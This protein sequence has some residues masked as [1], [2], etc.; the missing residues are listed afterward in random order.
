MLKRVPS[1]LVFFVAITLQAQ[2]PIRV[3]V[4]ATDAARK[5]FHAHLTIPAAPGPMKLAYAKWIPGEHSPT[6]PIVDLVNLRIAANGT[7]V[8]WRRDPG[9]MFVFLLDAPAGTTSLDVDLTYLSPIAGGNF[10]A[11]PNSTANLA[12]L[13]WNTLLLF[14][15]GKDAN[16]IFIEG[17][18]K[19]PDG[20]K[21]ASALPQSN[22]SFERASLA[23]YVDSP[24]IIGRYLKT[25]AIP[26]ASG[27]PAHRI[28]IVSESERDLIAPDDLAKQYARLA[29]EAGA[30]FGSYHFA[31][32][33]WLVSLSD[34]VAHFGLE[35]HQ[36]SDN[37]L[38]EATLADENGLRGL[39]GLLSHEYVH[40][41]NG[42]YRRPAA[43]LS[44]DYQQP[45]DGTL[46][47]V[48]EGLTEYMGFLLAARSGLWTPEHYRENLASLAAYYDVQPGRAWR[49]LADTATAA[50]IL[51]GAAEA[52]S[53]LRRSVDFYDESVLV[54]LEVDSILR[55]RTN[56]KA[57][58]DDFTRR[59]HGGRSGVAEVK[60]YT[61]DDVVTTLNAIAPYDWRSHFQSRVY[62]RTP[63]APLAG[64][65]ANGWK[66]AFD[67]KPNEAVASYETRRKVIDLTWSIG[68]VLREDGTVRDALMG[69]PAAGAGIG[70][71][72]KIIA[73]NGRRFTREVLES[74]L[75]DRSALELIVENNNFFRTH[76]V[77]YTGGVRYPHLVRDETVKDGLSELIA[78]KA[79]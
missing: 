28:N 59:F 58:L 47:W 24:V 72:M 64:L 66:L 40:S 25:F 60:P 30:A 37:R 49:P 70:P 3:S 17:S 26:V 20:W 69:Q 19:T 2:T 35:H 45:M 44:S 46:L 73:V 22:G 34:D 77:Q 31:H 54:W 51:Y 55:A 50:Q 1:I 10:T 21:I 39:G 7:P 27:T 75:K 76:A 42:K 52:W 78:A 33:D 16:E 62:A 15:P 57:S 36:S 29:A 18:M 41:W 65:A 5:V 79:K 67:E 32:Y 12:I 11:G 14:P 6:G 61:L 23:T 74:A 13:S 71:G 53:S 9:D 63:R 48:Y 4:D 56:G 8:E 43:L 68:L 38:P